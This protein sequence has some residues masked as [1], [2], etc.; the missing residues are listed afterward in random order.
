MDFG[1]LVGGIVFILAGAF[2]IADAVFRWDWDMRY[3]R[4][5]KGFEML[6]ETGM[7]KLYIFSGVA[8]VIIGVLMLMRF[9]FEI[10]EFIAS[11]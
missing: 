5:K 1:P 6:G 9:V 11:G 7:V 8:F 2:A 3:L 10:T 4:F